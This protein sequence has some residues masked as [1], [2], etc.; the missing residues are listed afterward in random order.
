MYDSNGVNF[1]VIAKKGFLTFPV[2]KNVLYNIPKVLK[3]LMKGKHRS[4]VI[5]SS[6]CQ[7]LPTYVYYICSTCKVLS[8]K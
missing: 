1:K 8:R 7:L 2:Q 6:L 3:N 4:E 5:H